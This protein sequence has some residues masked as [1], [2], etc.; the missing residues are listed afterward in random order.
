M[1]RR[2]DEGAQARSPRRSSPAGA[3]PVSVNAGRRGVVAR[4]RPRGRWPERGVKSLYGGSKFAGPQHDV[5]PAAS[6][7]LQPEGRAGH[8]AAKTASCALP[9]RRRPRTGARRGRGR[10]TRTRRRPEHERPVCAAVVTAARLVYATGESERGAAGVRGA[11]S[12][13][14]PHDE[15]RAGSEGSCGGSVGRASTREGVTGRTGSN[16][17]GG[18]ESID[19]VRQ[20]QRRLWSVAKRQPER[21]F[22]ALYDRIYRRD[23]LWEA[24]RRVKRNRGAA[25]IDAMTLADVE[26]LGGGGLSGGPRRPP[27]RRHVSARGGAAPVHSERQR[28]PTPIRDSD[29]PGP[30][31]PD[32]GDAG[33]GADFRGGLSAVLVQASGRSGVPRRRWKLCARVGREAGIT[34]STPTFATISAASTTASS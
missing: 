18:R 30:S 27:A 17:P 31:G 14:E 5:K 7:D 23:V 10:S 2:D 26:Q 3:S 24:W 25:G 9:V 11:R 12:S 4:H 19:Q 20:L 28:R 34:S 29:G 21:R 6:S 22:H 1:V 13:A 16:H 15:Q 33:A 32:G 8:V